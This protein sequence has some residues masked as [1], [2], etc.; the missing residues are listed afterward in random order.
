MAILRPEPA[1]FASVGEVG[2]SAA[3]AA[4]TCLT[5]P[6]KLQRWQRPTDELHQGQRDTAPSLPAKT[7]S[8]RLACYTTD[9]RQTVCAPSSKLVRPNPASALVA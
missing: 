6:D 8:C 7:A 2:E 1:G 3:P 4:E 5:V 9:R